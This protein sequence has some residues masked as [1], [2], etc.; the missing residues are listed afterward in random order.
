MNL[1]YIKLKKT[2]VPKS[3]D[4]SLVGEDFESGVQMMHENS[5]DQMDLE[6]KR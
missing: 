3:P 1:M 4:D 2:Q 5:G 6:D